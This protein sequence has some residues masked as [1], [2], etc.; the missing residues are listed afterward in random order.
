MLSKKIEKALNV[1]ITSEN[2]SAHYYLAMASW[3]DVNGLPG[4]A[5]FLYS[6]AEQERTHMTKLFHYING[7]GGHAVVNSF[8]APPAIFKSI[9]QIFKLV[10]ENEKEIT[11]QIND[12]V[13]LC[14]SEKDHSTFN[15]LQWYVAEQHEEEKLFRDVLDL[16]KRTGTD[17][18]GLYFIDK[19][20]GSL[21][22][23]VATA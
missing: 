10:Y 11:G 3:C 17:G 9:E 21:S 23:K 5:R 1:Q 22:N 2:S 16:I 6:H 19:E 13:D 20:I 15:F 4:A 14:L 8:K 18:R 7:T 12:L